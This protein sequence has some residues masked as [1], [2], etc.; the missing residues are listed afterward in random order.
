MTMLYYP[1]ILTGGILCS[2]RVIWENATG[3]QFGGNEAQWNDNLYEFYL[4]YYHDHMINRYS[5]VKISYTVWL[6]MYLLHSFIPLPCAECDHSLPF[7]P[8]CS[9]PP[10]Y[11]LFP[12]TV[13]HQLF[14]HPPSL[15]LAIYFMVYLL[16]CRF[17]IHIQYSFGNSISFHSLYMSKPMYCM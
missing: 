5:D 10:C 6:A 11:I 7:P 3:I 4:Q 9:I 15:H 2:S 14:F 8:A 1:H 13:L 12:I 17:R 16:V